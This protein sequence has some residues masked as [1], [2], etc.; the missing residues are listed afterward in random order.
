MTVWLLRRFGLHQV[1]SEY[2]FAHQLLPRPNV[3]NS[4]VVEVPMLLQVCTL[5]IQWVLEM[6]VC[7]CVCVPQDDKGIIT[8]M[9]SFYHLPSTVISNPKHKVLCRLCVRFCRCK[10]CLCG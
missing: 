5:P 4:Y 8:D 1:F 3:V 7:V 2:D 9:C 6:C 10:A